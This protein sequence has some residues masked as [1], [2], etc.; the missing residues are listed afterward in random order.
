MTT[1]TKKL[2]LVPPDV[3]NSLRSQ[4]RV[5]DIQHPELKVSQT[6]DKSMNDIL[7]HPNMSERDKLTLYNQLLQ[8]LQFHLGGGG[9]TEGNTSSTFPPPPP[10]PPSATA[11]AAVTTQPPALNQDTPHRPPQTPGGRHVSFDKDI[12][13]E[14]QIMSSVPQIYQRTTKSFL[15]YLKQNGVEWNDD[16]SISINKRIYPGSNIIDIVNHTLRQRKKT[17]YPPMG[18]IPLIQ[19]LKQINVPLEYIGNKSLWE[20][21]ANTPTTPPDTPREDPIYNKFPTKK[22]RQTKTQAKEK[23]KR[24][25]KY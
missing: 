19:H 13:W 4:Q 1:S 5:E 18:A 11:T 3:M 2:F 22:A 12:T 10:P 9:G 24:W 8:Q 14:N 21:V 25:L 20:S 16:G 7:Q 6:I 15:K 23:I 17:P